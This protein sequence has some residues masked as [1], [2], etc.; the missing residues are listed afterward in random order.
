[1]NIKRYVKT[2]LVSSVIYFLFFYCWLKLNPS[3]FSPLSVFLWCQA[4]AL[5]TISISIIDIIGFLFDKNWIIDKTLLGIKIVEKLKKRSIVLLVVAGYFL[6]I[7]LKFIFVKFLYRLDIIE[8]MVSVISNPAISSSIYPFMQV[9][10]ILSIVFSQ[11]IAISM[12]FFSRSN[13]VLERPSVRMPGK[14]IKKDSGLIYDLGQLFLYPQLQE[15]RVRWHFANNEIQSALFILCGV[16]I[17]VCYHLTSTK[18]CRYCE[19][20]RGGTQDRIAR[21]KIGF[22]AFISREKLLCA[23][24]FLYLLTAYLQWRGIAVVMWK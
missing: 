14:R 15:F 6:L 8:K 20:V 18:V 4:T 12:L 2:I 10:I 7:L 11:A 13:T 17:G 16:V 3:P 21:E 5:Y 19:L 22:I 23:Y 24:V 1:M 9:E